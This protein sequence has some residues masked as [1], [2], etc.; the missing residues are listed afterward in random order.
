MLGYELLAGEPSLNGDT[1]QAILSAHVLK[2][3][4]GR[5]QPV[6]ALAF[7]AQAGGWKDTATLLRSYQQADEATVTQVVLTAPKLTATGV[8]AVEVTPIALPRRDRGQRCTSRQDA[9]G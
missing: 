7:E 9:A 8:Q 4:R 6:R 3:P 2:P 1:P 5:K